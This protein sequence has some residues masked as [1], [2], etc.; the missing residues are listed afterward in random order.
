MSKP[1]KIE[2][3]D[4]FGNTWT[5]DVDTAGDD[6]MQDDEAYAACDAAALE[7]ANVSWTVIDNDTGD[8]E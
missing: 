7:A 6:P 5:V 4:G 3:T 8:T 2:V 1:T